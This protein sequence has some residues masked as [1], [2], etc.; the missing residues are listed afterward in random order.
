MVAGG[1]VSGKYVYAP[2][3]GDRLRLIADHEKHGE[4]IRVVVCEKRVYWLVM[5]DR[6]TFWYFSPE[7]WELDA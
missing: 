4:F 2:Q 7:R 6:S 3:P 5:Q 1:D